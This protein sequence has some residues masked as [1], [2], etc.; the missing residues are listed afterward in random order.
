MIGINIGSLNSSLAF[1]KSQP[2]QLLFKSELLLSDTSLRTCP[3]IISFTQTHRLIGDQA[4]LVI[5]KNIKSSFQNLNRLIGFDINSPFSQTE[6]NKYYYIGGE[7]NS[8]QKKFCCFGNDMLFPEEIVIS[9]L[10][11]LYNSY[12][13]EKSIEAEY[14][15][16]SVP[17]YFTCFH[18]NS[19]KKII[20]SINLKKNYSL[21]NESSAI[22]LYF[23]YK[24]YKEYFINKR[25]VNNQI[26]SEIDPNIIKHVLFIDA[27]HSKINLIFSKLT[28]G[29]FQVLNSYTIPFLGGRDFD[30]KIYELCAK[31]FKDSY[32]IDIS[33]DN[34]IKIRLMNPIMKARKALTVNKDSHINV[35]SLKDDNDL[36]L[37]LTRED[38]E[39]LI[40]E[41]LLLFKNELIKFCDYNN[42][43][44]PNAMLTNIEMAGELM[45]TPCLQNIVK[46]VTGFSVS[47]TI[48]TDECIAIGCSLYGSLLNGTF[49]IKDFNGIYH[50]NNYT[51][52]ISINNEPINKFI[53]NNEY[54]PAYKPYFFDEKYFNSPNSKIIIS[55]YY[56]KNEIKNYLLSDTGLL[57]TFEF[58]C[59]E[60]VKL[61]GGMKNVKITFL[62]SN[63]GFI[64]IHTL[65][66][67]VIEDQYIKIDINNNI[68]KIIN[69]KI[70]PDSKET[71]KMIEEYKNKEK[72]LFEKDRYFISYSKLKNNTLNKLYNF[73]NK[74]ND[75]GLGD[76]YFENKKINEI[77][78]DYEMKLNDSN[79][80][81]LN[82]E[83]INEYL[84]KIVSN[85]IND[86]LKNKA[87]ELLNKISD[88]QNKLSE[89]YQKL[90]SGNQCS[91]EENQIND[92]SNM[93][94]HFIK[95]LNLVLSKEELNNIEIEFEREIKKYF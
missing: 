60:I 49:P 94:E 37:I 41:E 23:G 87:K 81:L 1:G 19:F 67:R 25:Q 5:K 15:V 39:K 76:N 31:N 57:V 95:K 78:D 42:K 21:I 88:Y 11:L 2:N 26:V 59:E 86:D 32:G 58:N 24:K 13:L 93:L 8:Q 35:D 73:R 74:I 83:E 10:H 66:S 12:I 27:G 43:N 7:F 38:F 72:I 65:E 70:Y 36:S 6:Y 34:K 48:L 53:G 45:R 68:Y 82:L 77:L 71:E 92:A 69:R 46:E 75:S 64:H 55:F 54:L 18:K 91:L 4:S 62:I 90:L 33:N 84:D 47:K 50:L 44:F 56:D 85:L 3:T 63:M 89:E 17:D 52:N 29:L 9:Y 40:G 16:F 20:D 51:M 22:T 30:N 80:E 14:F 61:N 28:F 79:N